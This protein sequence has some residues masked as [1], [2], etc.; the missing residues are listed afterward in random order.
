MDTSASDEAT[1]LVRYTCSVESCA[2]IATVLVDGGPRSDLPLCGE[3]WQTARSLASDGLAAVMVLPRPCC[4]VAA[5]GS[6]ALEIVV[7]LDGT[8]LPCCERHIEDL[9]WVTPG[10]CYDEASHA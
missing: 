4:F 7:H 8:L 9:C 1:G 6:P 5:C 10:S 2:E 3:H